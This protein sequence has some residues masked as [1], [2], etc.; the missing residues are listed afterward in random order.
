MSNTMITI[1]SR[2][3]SVELA[4]ANTQ[5]IHIFTQLHS[6]LNTKR[7]LGYVVNDFLHY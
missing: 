3:L 7:V 4:E 5:F 6:H 2:S 1:M